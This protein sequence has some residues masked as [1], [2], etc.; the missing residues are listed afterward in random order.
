MLAAP[1]CFGE[2][3]PADSLAELTD[4]QLKARVLHLSQRLLDAWRAEDADLHLSHLLRR[5]VRVPGVQNL[6]TDSEKAELGVGP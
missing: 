4:A 1:F 2:R 5:A 3:G 6:L